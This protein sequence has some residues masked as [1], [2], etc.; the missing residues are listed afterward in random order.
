MAAYDTY[1][2]YDTHETYDTYETYNTYD[3]YEPDTVYYDMDPT[4]E[5]VSLLIVVF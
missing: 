3:T 5:R 4:V 1:D 2:T